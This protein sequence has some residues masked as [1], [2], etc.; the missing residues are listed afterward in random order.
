MRS[1][2]LAISNYTPHIYGEALL[3][4]TFASLMRI[5]MIPNIAVSGIPDPIAGKMG[6]MRKQNSTNNLW[7]SIN[8]TA[9]FQ[10]ATQSHTFKTLKARDIL[11]IQSFCTVSKVLNTFKSGTI[12]RAIIHCVLVRV[13]RCTM[14]I[15]LSSSATSLYLQFRKADSTQKGTPFLE[16]TGQ[17]E[18]THVDE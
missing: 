17:H 10:P 8:S 9:E 1:S 14:S 4:V 11:R 3:V 16:V 5:V 12:R 2:Q 13:L 7:F 15:T 18:R 6:F